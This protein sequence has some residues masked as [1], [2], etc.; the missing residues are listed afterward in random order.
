MQLVD[1]INWEKIGGLIPVIVQD[2][3]TA[4]VLMLGYMNREALTATL[5]QNVVIFYSRSKQRLWMKGETSDNT[6]QL[7]SITID[8]DQDALLIQATPLGPTCHSGETSCFASLK[9]P[10]TQILTNLAR[11]IE[12]RV[13]E[14]PEKSYTAELVRSGIH[15]VAQK[16]GEESVEVVVA[17]LAQNRD[18][19]IN[20]SADL[21]YHLLV[22]LSVRSVSLEEVLY[23][24]AARAA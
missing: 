6:L 16:V 22:L 4:M 3:Q 13:A 5:Q 15:R 14:L 9:Q 21:L 17:A 23:C 12:S 20:E 8:C 7:Q 1:T 24:L 2:S 11:T 19:L 10:T 18:A